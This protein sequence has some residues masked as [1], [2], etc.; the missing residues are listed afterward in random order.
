MRSPFPPQELP[1]P[2]IQLAPN[3]PTHSRLFPSPEQIWRSSKVTL[4]DVKYK[5]FRVCLFFL[6]SEQ[7]WFLKNLN[8]LNLKF[9]NLQVVLFLSF[10]DSSVKTLPS[11]LKKPGL[12]DSAPGVHS[13]LL[14]LTLP[15]HLNRMT[16]SHP[17]LTWGW[18]VSKTSQAEP[19]IQ[20]SSFW[21]ALQDLAKQTE[22][23]CSHAH[24]ERT[25]N[26]NLCFTSTGA[27]TWKDTWE[28]AGCLAPYS[29]ILASVAHFCSHYSCFSAAQAMEVW[30]ILLDILISNNK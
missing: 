3:P 25:W 26:L 9:K 1:T 18:E 16:I 27:S 7:R 19:F 10:K 4:V 5:G 30:N 29:D 21:K 11:F 28:D 13:L 24:W 23:P 8:I 12:C 2:Y 15:W 14:S 20:I 6:S 17:N 22:K